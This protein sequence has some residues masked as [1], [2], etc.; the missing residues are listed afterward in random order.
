MA[1]LARQGSQFPITMNERVLEQLNL[2]LGT[3]D[4]RAYLNASL[5]RKEPALRNAIQ[6]CP[7]RGGLVSHDTNLPSRKDCRSTSYA[8][9]A[10]L[11]AIEAS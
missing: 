10:C 4:G 7:S 8:T 9:F 3:P 5:A 2:L 6:V 11:R 1:V